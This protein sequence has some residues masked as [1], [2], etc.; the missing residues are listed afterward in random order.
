MS[1]M[2]TCCWA[3]A[4]NIHN[5]PWKCEHGTPILQKLARKPIQFIDSAIFCR[6]QAI[7]KG[8]WDLW[9]P[10]SPVL[11][12]RQSPCTPASHQAP[13][14]RWRL[15]M[16]DAGRGAPIVVTFSVWFGS[17]FQEHNTEIP[18]WIERFPWKKGDMGKND[19]STRAH[20][21]TVEKEPHGDWHSLNVCTVCTLDLD[22][23]GLGYTK[24]TKW[25]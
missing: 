19:H 22:R 2:C 18:C 24:I 9:L 7:V 3:G 25:P 17:S 23:L 6:C 4:S 10:A 13:Q 14:R 8:I 12:Q 21:L 5:P 1:I 15:A 16:G 20:G 11:A